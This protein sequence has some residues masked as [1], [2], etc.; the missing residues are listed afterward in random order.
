MSRLPKYRRSLAPSNARDRFEYERD[1]RE[2][3]G[4]DYDKFR[5][6]PTREEYLKALRKGREEN[7]EA[8]HERAL[9]WIGHASGIPYVLSKE[10]QDRYWA[11][12][13][14]KRRSVTPVE[15]L[16]IIR[17]VRRKYLTKPRGSR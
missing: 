4:D 10:A 1:E 7:R 12:A 14:E 2:W 13:R 17:D 16:Q 15:D 8:S 9:R 11:L 5:S 3:W 6:L